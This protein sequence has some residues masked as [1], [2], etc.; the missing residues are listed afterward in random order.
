MDFYGGDSDDDAGGGSE[1]GV[2]EKVHLENFRVHEVRKHDQS[3]WVDV[4][5]AHA[6]AGSGVES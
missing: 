6:G 2:I 3:S 4:D 5:D 1:C